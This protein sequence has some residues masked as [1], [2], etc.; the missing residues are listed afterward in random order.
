MIDYK[1]IEEAFL[2]VSSV[3]YLEAQAYL[4]KESGKIYWYAEFADITEDLPED[5]DDEKYVQIPHKKELGLGKPLVMNFASEY[6]EDELPEIQ[7]SFRREG[8]YS[9]FKMRLER[10]GLLEKWY[11]YE[12]NAEDRALRKWCRLN[13]I[14]VT[15]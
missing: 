2:F 11:E 10:R 14:D 13:E 4:D 15:G 6:L 3:P 5:L 12:S 8:A 9:R 7:L 1:E